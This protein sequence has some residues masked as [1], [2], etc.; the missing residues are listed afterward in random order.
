LTVVPARLV[1][2]QG[3]FIAFAQASFKGGDGGVVQLEEMVKVPVFDEL[4]VE[5][6][7]ETYA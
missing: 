7:Y 4:P 6:Q 1:V 5:D 2:P 3:R